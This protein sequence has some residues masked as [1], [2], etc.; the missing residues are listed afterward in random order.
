MLCEPTE[1][2]SMGETEAIKKELDLTFASDSSKRND[3]TELLCAKA[4]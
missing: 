1:P 3:H 4:T 2:F